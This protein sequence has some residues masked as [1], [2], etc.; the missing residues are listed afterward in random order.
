VRAAE[1][2]SKAGPSATAIAVRGLTRYTTL[3]LPSA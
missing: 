2:D 3:S 1:L